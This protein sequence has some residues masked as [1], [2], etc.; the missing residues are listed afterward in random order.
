MNLRT[1]SAEPSSFGK[2]KLNMPKEFSGN[3]EDFYWWMMSFR[4]YIAGNHKVYPNI[5]DKINF[6]LS[7]RGF[8]NQNPG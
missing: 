7:S 6:V 8:G 5:F 2:K 3:R 4:M 1:E